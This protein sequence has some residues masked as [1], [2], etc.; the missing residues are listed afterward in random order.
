MT[1]SEMGPPA[2]TLL[3]LAALVAMLR[4]RRPPRAP[5]PPQEL[6]RSPEP[7]PA[8]RPGAIIRRRIVLG[9]ALEV[10]GHPALVVPANR[11][12]TLG[13][14]SH[15]AELVAHRAGP[16]PEREALAAHPDGVALGEA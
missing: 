13:W 10:E 6:W 16:D 7:G 14:G 12:L 1:L 4:L 9:D 2:L 15:L 8:S 11:Q 3:L 5:G